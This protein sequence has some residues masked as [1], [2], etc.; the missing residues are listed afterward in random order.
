MGVPKPLKG[1]V[2]CEACAAMLVLGG[3]RCT[4]PKNRQ[5]SG[6][7]V[8][9]DLRDLSDEDVPWA[10]QVQPITNLQARFNFLLASRPAHERNLWRRMPSPEDDFEYLM[11]EMVDG[12]PLGRKW[13]DQLLR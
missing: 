13:A 9:Y 1:P 6:L 7:T 2:M 5:L 12:T 10:P 8:S 4:D 11:K 3:Y